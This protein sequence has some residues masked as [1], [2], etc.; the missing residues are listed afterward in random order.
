MTAH[1]SLFPFGSS[2]EPHN[3]LNTRPNAPTAF[4]PSP[5][6]DNLIPYLILGYR[7]SIVSQERG[8]RFILDSHLFEHETSYP[9]YVST[10]VVKDLPIEIALRWITSNRTA[11][12]RCFSLR[13]LGPVS[14]CSLDSWKLSVTCGDACSVDPLRS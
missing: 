12:K 7:A 5:G 9:Y 8:E 2:G 10:V 13:S 6:A 11:Q 4:V 3:R 1:V 14:G